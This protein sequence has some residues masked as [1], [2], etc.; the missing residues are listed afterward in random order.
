MAKRIKKTYQKPSVESEKILET[1]ALACGKCLAGG[2]IG[3]TACKTRS[4]L[5]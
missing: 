3:Q 1:A 4:R 2:P 5:S